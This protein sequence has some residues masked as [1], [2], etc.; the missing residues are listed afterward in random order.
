[1]YQEHLVESS[2]IHSIAFDPGGPSLK[3]EFHSKG[4][5]ENEPRRV[6]EYEEVGEALFQE[7]LSSP[8]KGTFF[9]QKI[10]G[11]FPARRIA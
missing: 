5:N 10:R 7:F 4:K 11:R 9:Q 3:V 8:S 2:N 6:Y 1:M